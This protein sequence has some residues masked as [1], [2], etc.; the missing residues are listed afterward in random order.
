MGS[1]AAVGPVVPECPRQHARSGGRPALAQG[2]RCLLA[3]T[4]VEDTMKTRYLMTLALALSLPL[5]SLADTG[6]SAGTVDA[7][8]D[9]FD[10]SADCNDLDP[11]VH[12][13]AAEQCNFV[14]D[15]CDGQ[16]DED[17][18]PQ[19]LGDPRIESTF[20]G[21][22]HLLEPDDANFEL[23][24]GR[25]TLIKAHVL[26]A[27]HRDDVQKVVAL[28]KLGTAH[29]TIALGGPDTVPDVVCLAPG[30]G[31]HRL[32]DAY[33]GIIPADWVAPGLRVKVRVLRAEQPA[34]GDYDKQ[35]YAPAV[36]APT[37]LPLNMFDARFFGVPEESYPAGWQD[38][39]AEK[40][41]VA[42]L[43][44]QRIPVIFPEVV[45]PPR[46]AQGREGFRVTSEAEYTQQTGH[47]LGMA[48]IRA[49]IQI[50]DAL[51]VAGA[52]KQRSLTYVNVHGFPAGGL[53][54]PSYG[55]GG[56]M[57]G[58]L[59]HE[60][61]H[62]LDLQHLVDE[63]D[64]PYFGDEYGI[65]GP[66]GSGHRVGP[67]W[68]LDLR[69]V[70]SGGAPYFIPPTV[71][72][73]S[74]AAGQ[75]LGYWKRS[76]MQRVGGVGD[77]YEAGF[78]YQMF[79]DWGVRRMRDFIQEHYGVWN[80]ALGDYARWDDATGDYTAPLPGYVTPLVAHDVPVVSVMVAA[81]GAKPA[82]DMVYPPIGPYQGALI[83]RYDPTVAADLPAA[84]AKYCPAAGC[85]L[86]VRITQ[87]GQT[88][89]YMLAGEWDA[90]L[91]PTS[92]SSL[93]TRAI[94]LPAADGE[95]TAVELYHTPNVEQTGLAP[96]FHLGQAP[97][98][99]WS[100]T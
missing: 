72:A 30:Q 79:S 33:V 39:L 12:P 70:A 13:G 38:E 15:D 73:S 96:N 97:L 69:A 64:Y 23:V 87:G 91:D 76:P 90:T 83:R 54:Q 46:E 60:L 22:T 28:L 82:L 53:G 41:P 16:T 17:F 51:A 81:S 21:Q 8:A 50:A 62:V 98:A 42:S 26:A 92:E 36:G 2:L 57:A 61:G 18:V 71:Q 48:P 9:G 49:G 86:T 74:P 75:W 58:F 4:V 52:Q 78:L 35:W 56:V 32:D 3:N 100:A 29:T 63:A 47:A 5:P 34:L 45:I 93:V 94:N 85:D 89:T 68:G 77:D 40:L 10:A 20:F 43:E 27:T 31:G 44:V 67:Q 11:T 99:T 55:A 37:A 6:G 84:D 65:P 88:R 66:G 7:D 80:P 24:G 59:V 19:G 25:D 95:V 14:D 1:K